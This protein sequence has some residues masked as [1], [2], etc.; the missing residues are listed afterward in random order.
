MLLEN[1]ERIIEALRRANV[2]DG[3]VFSTADLAGVA[4]K[5]QAAPACHVVLLDYAPV[6]QVGAEVEWREIWC[7]WV[8]VKNVARKDRP[9]AQV[10]EATAIIDHALLALLS[11]MPGHRPLK[12]VEGPVPDFSL[13]HA[14][15][16]LA[17][18]AR[19]AT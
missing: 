18:E 1:G 19:S 10:A 8:V 13:T 2:A 9:A 7:V 5:D 17:F 16:P 4:E 15:F 11:P 3:R 12:I 6:G 14:Y